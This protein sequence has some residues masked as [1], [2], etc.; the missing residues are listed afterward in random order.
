M[1]QG[2]GSAAAPVLGVAPRLRR[3]QIIA[4][5]HS[6]SVGP[7]AAAEAESIAHGLGFDAEARAVAPHDL[8]AQLQA[9]VAVGPDLLVVIAGDGTAN[10]AASLCGPDGP[11]LAPLAGGTMNMLPR[12]LY[13]HRDWKSALRAILEDGAVMPVAGGD[14]D[15]N[16]FH[17]AAILGN[18]AL[19]APARE[20]IRDGKLREAVHRAVYA[21]RR[22]FRSKLHYALDGPMHGRA[23]GLGLL[24]PIV[25]QGISDDTLALEAAAANP[26][27]MIGV[28][29]LGVE[30]LVLPSLSAAAGAGWRHSPYVRTGE[31][32]SG[33]ASGRRHIHA[34]LDGEPIRLPKYVRIRFIPMAF[35]ALVA[36]SDKG[37]PEGGG[38]SI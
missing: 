13:G 22:A 26:P 4:N 35:R 32:T 24:C 25:S 23:E 15:G 16:A 29:R 1:M 2:E 28:L 27:G 21:W 7:G 19:W 5:E 9:A 37:R 34:V 14:I 17:V 18:P 8:R 6:G 12:A 20:A 3:I 31:C 33:H 36:A 38:A 30:A 10:M 11:L